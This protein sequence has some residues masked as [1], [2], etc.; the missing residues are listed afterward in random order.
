MASRKIED[1]TQRMIDLY[2][3]F[4][5]AMKS[6][7]IPFIVTCTARTF[8]EQVALYAQGRQALDE[9]NFLRKKAGLS[10]ITEKENQRQVTWTLSSKHIVNWEDDNPENDR[11][12]A[13]DFA[14]L[15]PGGKAH[16]D[17]KANVNKNEVSDYQEAGLIGESVGLVWGGRFRKK[18]MCHFEQPR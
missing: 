18:D 17:L 1:M 14:L 12:M 4:E 3:K 10:L 7:G 8:Q 15:T 5:N 11:A 9:T 6:A 13:F 16:W 2:Y